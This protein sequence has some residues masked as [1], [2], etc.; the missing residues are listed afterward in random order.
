[1]KTRESIRVSGG[2][3]LLNPELQISIHGADGSLS[4][5][6]Q[7]EP[8]LVQRI[9]KESQRPEFFAQGRIILAGQFSLTTFVVSNIARIDLAGEGISAWKPKPSSEAPDLVEISQQ[10]FL[11]EA[12]ERE[13]QHVERPKRQHAPGQHFVGY[14]DIQ[15]VNGQHV[16]LKFHGVAALP[17]ERLQRV[18]SFLTLPS[19]SFRMPGGGR[20]ILNLSKAAKFT[21]CPGPAEV[22]AGAWVAKEKQ[23]HQV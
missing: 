4:T 16:Y 1:M 22:P 10:E 7:D 12:E 23:T 2:S 6:T 17:A 13:L 18:H 20:G 8:A 21:A 15:M 5:F 3:D 9:I 14:L 19:L 11:G